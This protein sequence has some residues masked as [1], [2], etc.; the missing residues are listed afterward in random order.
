MASAGVSPGAMMAQREPLN[1]GITLTSSGLSL[2]PSRST[3]SGT[4]QPTPMPKKRAMQASMAEMASRIN[5]LL[6]AVTQLTEKDRP[7]TEGNPA[8]ITEDVAFTKV[9]VMID[10]ELV[11]VGRK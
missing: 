10:S 1:A 3:P 6:K 2:E 4:R 9:E 11:S 8:A 5:T 7:V